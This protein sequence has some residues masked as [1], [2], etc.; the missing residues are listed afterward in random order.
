MKIKLSSN[1]A[2][3]ITQFDAEMHNRWVELYEKLKEHY[4]NKTK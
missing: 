4:A 2:S 3:V 1:A